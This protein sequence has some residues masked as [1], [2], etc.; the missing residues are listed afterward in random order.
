MRTLLS[1]PLNMLLLFFY[2]LIIFLSSPENY[3][4]DSV[5]ASFSIP[6]SGATLTITWNI[7]F[8]LIGIAILYI[9]ILKSTRATFQALLDHVLSLC[10]FVVFLVELLIVREMGSATFLILTL[11]SL[12]D[13]IA[14]FTVSL[15]TARRDITIEG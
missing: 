4:P 1:I 2:N 6:S 11:L 8:V 9:E 7:L 5:V 14:G 15:S 12:V 3:I 13:V 10:V